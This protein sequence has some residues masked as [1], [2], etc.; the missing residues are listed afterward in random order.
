MHASFELLSRLEKIFVTSNKIK[1]NKIKVNSF[2]T[3][4][5]IPFRGEIAHKSIAIN[6]KLVLYFHMHA[7]HA[8][9]QRQLRK[10]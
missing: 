7:L 4:F 8:Y 10:T 6:Y 9:V 5:V 2:V 1:S 3:E